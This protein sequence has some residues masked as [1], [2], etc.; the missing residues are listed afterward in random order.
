[1][2]NP[3]ARTVLAAAA[4][5]LALV[6]TGAAPATA[7]PK[8][9]GSIS[10][11]ANMSARISFTTNYSGSLTFYSPGYGVKYGAVSWKD[12]SKR[13][14]RSYNAPRRGPVSWMFLAT[15]ADNFYATCSL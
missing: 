2:K 11:P 7:G 6:F 15:G 12:T 14:Y 3:K 1:M 8:V 4:V 5:S 9:G 13:V 10:C